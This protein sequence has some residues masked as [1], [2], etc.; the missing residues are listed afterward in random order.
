MDINVVEIRKLSYGDLDPLTMIFGSEFNRTHQDDLIDQEQELI[1]FYV[2][3]L[4]N[5]PI[6]HGLVNWGGARDP[7]IASA[8]PGCPEI[9]RLS[10]L[11]EFQSRGVG[12]RLLQACEQEAIN[13]K[14]PLI[15]IS[16]GHNNPRALA[17]YKRLGFRQSTID[18]CIFRYRRQLGTGEVIWFEEAGTW[19]IKTL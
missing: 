5:N 6:G 17:L 10:V 15:G 7:E 9:Y 2:A 13:R 14:L 8:Y 16:V 3:W 19:M 1:S 12:T 4:Q 18:N 11:Q